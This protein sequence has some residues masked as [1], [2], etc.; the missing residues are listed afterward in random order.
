M[1]VDGK[2]DTTTAEGKAVWKAM[3]GKD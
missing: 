2:I 3:G 1:F